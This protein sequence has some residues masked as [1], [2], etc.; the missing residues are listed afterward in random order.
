MY[1]HESHIGFIVA[2]Y[3]VA[4]VVI[5]SMIAA[6]VRDYRSLKKSLGR[7]GARGLDRE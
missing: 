5:L 3:V 4:A 2:A 1:A 7:F 6:T